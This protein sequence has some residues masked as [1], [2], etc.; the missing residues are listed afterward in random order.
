M[1]ELFAYNEKAETIFDLI[2]DKENE[3][4]K[5]SI[6]SSKQNGAGSFQESRS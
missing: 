1:A 5:S 3:I 4:T 2:G 6:S